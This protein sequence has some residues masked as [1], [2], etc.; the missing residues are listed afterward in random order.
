MSVPKGLL[1]VLLLG[2]LCQ[3]W[4]L[5]QLRAVHPP[6]GVLAPADPVQTDLDAQPPVVHGRWL[7]K[8]RARYDITARILSREDY[9][10]DAIADL[11]PEDLALGWG[12]MSDNRILQAFE[13]TQ[14][15]RFYFWRPR[16]GLPLPREVVIEHSAN[17][18][19]IPSDAF[20]RSQLR[21]LR[22]GQVVHLSGW[23]VDGARNDGRTTFHTS[24]TR[25]D[26]GPGACEIML[27]QEVEIEEALGS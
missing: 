27:V 10:F 20:V 21:K 24:M 18:H 6:D 22:V 11:V 14:D 2:A 16:H 9:H 4:L 15:Y 13:I 19:V 17:T 12:P 3:G 25:T 8:P 26:T 7:L 23:L 5:W 1:L